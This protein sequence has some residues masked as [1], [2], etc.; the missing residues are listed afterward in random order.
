[1][2]DDIP[3]LQALARYLYV[4]LCL[5]LMVDFVSPAM[6]VLTENGSVIG[7]IANLSSPPLLA[8]CWL[9]AASAIVP[10]L[11][12]QLW[13]P[14]CHYRRLIIKLASYGLILGALTW[15]FIAFLARNLDYQF[16]IWNFLFYGLASLAMAGLMSY[17]L[18][19]DQKE[20][21]YDSVKGQ[22]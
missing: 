5:E 17:G 6:W 9:I 2:T 20:I 10:F 4:M 8:V 16:A 15:V 13:W 21:F 12:M 11:V 19:N 18:N 3:R 14:C 22:L 1:M 7:R